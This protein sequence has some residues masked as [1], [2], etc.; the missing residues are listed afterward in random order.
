LLNIAVQIKRRAD[1]NDDGNANAADNA[2]HG[3]LPGT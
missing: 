1:G 3:V 2:V